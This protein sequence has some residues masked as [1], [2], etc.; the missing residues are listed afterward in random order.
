MI[1]A[2]LQK[3]RTRSRSNLYFA[4]AF[5]PARKREAFRHVYR[6]LREADD[7]SDG[8]LPPEEARRRLQGFRDRID[9]VLAAPE[10]AGLALERAHVAT[11]LDGLDE[12]ADPARRFATPAE[13]ERWCEAV[14]GTLGLLCLAILDARE[15]AAYGRDV[16]VALQLAN[17]VRDLAVDAQNGRNYLPGAPDTSGWSPAVERAARE[18]ADRARALV[19]RARA[20]LDPALRR[21]LLVPEIWADVYLA[22]LDELEAARFDVWGERP[23][24]SRRRKLRLALGRFLVL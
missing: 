22:L 9:R 24:L 15:A 8:G 19:A 11:I 21:R 20:G 4:L 13:L 2:L 5:L 6:F 14:S 16:G 18:L 23:Y 17:I 10:V 3:L 1:F 7:V 12:D